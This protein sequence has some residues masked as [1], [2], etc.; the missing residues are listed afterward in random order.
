MVSRAEKRKIFRDLGRLDPGFAEKVMPFLKGLYDYYFRCEISG[1]GNVPKGKAIFVGNHNGLLTFE[2]LMLFYAWFSHFGWSR[3]ALGLSHDVALR[4]PAFSWLIP[5]LGAIPADPEIALEAL[6]RDYSLMAFP[7]GEK[8]AF[9]PFSRRKHVEFYGR[10]GFIRLAR[11]ARVPLVPIV[12]IGAAES[13]IILKRGERIAEALGLKKYF[14]L[15]GV[16]IT[17]RGIFFAWCM[18]TGI[19]TFFP[20]LL[21]PG[22]LLSVFIP[23]PTKMAFRILPPI[24]INSVW[25]DDRSEDE[26][27]EIIYQQITHAMQQVLTE[28]YSKRRFPILG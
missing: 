10:K 18:V 14:R 5:K 16:P 27:L 26:N 13:Y 25:N 3:R 22:A 17:F 4:N 11:A 28:E 6:E 8:E 7:G 24:D 1:W 19:F 2:V 9:R 21:A 12:S 15:H 20:L 23:L